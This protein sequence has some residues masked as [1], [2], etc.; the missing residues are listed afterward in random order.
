MSD[1]SAGGFFQGKIVVITG[2]ASGIGLSCAQMLASRGAKVVVADVNGEGARAAA[3]SMGG[4]AYQLDVAS[5]AEICAVAARIEKEIGPVEMVVANAGILQP[6]PYPP[7]EFPVDLWDRLY[8]IDV[9]GV[10][11]TCAE[12]GRAMALRGRG[13]IV[14]IASVSGF[15]S[16]P[17]HAY[18]SAKA[19]VAQMAMNLAAEWGRSGVRV[20]ALSPGYVLTPALKAAADAGHRDTRTI[21]ENSALGRMVLPEEIAKACA[22][23]LSDEA[24]A[25]TGINLVVDN[26]WAVAGSWHTYGGLNPKRTTASY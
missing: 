25:V 18:S 10:F 20:N 24:S 9:R 15:R 13:S 2:A 5:P 11:Y 4:H 17:L 3:A 8:A 6:N 26:G 7:E 16:N 12:F 14:A 22:F 1:Q 21:A 23:L 19:A